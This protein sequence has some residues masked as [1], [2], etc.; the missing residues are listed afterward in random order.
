ML[1]WGRVRATSLARPECSPTPAAGATW[2]SSCGGIGPRR[3]LEPRGHRGDRRGAPGRGGSQTAA[4]LPDAGP[5]DRQLRERLVAGEIE[6]LIVLLSPLM[7][8]AGGPDVMPLLHATDIHNIPVAT[9]LATAYCLRQWASRR[10]TPPRARGDRRPARAVS[11]DRTRRRGAAWPR[12]ESLTTPKTSGILRR[13][14]PPGRG[15]AAPSTPH[16]AFERPPVGRAWWPDGRAATRRRPIRRD[17][18][19]QAGQGALRPRPEHSPRV[20]RALA[21]RGLGGLVP[22]PRGAPPDSGRVDPL[23]DFSTELWA[24]SGPGPGRPC[25]RNLGSRPCRRRDAGGATC[26]GRS[27]DRN[28]YGV[29][30]SRQQY[31]G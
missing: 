18:R 1:E 15:P 17:R 7:R 4:V 29:V 23:L 28:I 11:R 9:N 8:P 30:I 16:E 2:S 3:R 6:R 26:R 19:N 24:A 10:R 5:E 27:T 13:R 25:F 21:G 20:A 22:R 14:R 12:R 31:L